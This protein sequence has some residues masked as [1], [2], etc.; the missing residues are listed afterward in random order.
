ML[1]V[2]DRH[3]DDLRLFDS[4]PALLQVFRR[5]ESAEVGQAIVH[6]ISSPLLDNPM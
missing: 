3:L 1:H 4:A 6:A 2:T 5:D